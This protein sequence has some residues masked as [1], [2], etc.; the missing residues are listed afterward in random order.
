MKY[1]FC[2]GAAGPHH[3]A[4]EE[5]RPPLRQ[6]ACVGRAA[7]LEQ[8][9][10]TAA[11]SAAV[12]AAAFRRCVRPA[13]LGLRP[14]LSRPAGAQPGRPARLLFGA[15]GAACNLYEPPLSQRVLL[16]QGIPATA[17]LS[18]P[19]QHCRAR[20]AGGSPPWLPTPARTR[21]TLPGPP[22]SLPAAPLRPAPC[23]PMSGPRVGG[24]WP[25]GDRCHYR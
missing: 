7:P 21:P 3:R 5:L 4:R 2:L 17:A 22:G 13:G 15:R 14:R 20:E 23:R 10:M 24:G 25:R 9:A 16:P 11:V 12:L 6:G 19:P 18:P 8:P 1:L